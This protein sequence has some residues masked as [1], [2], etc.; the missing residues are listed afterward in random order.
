M[1][2]PGNMPRK[3]FVT[4]CSGPGARRT[5]SCNTHPRMNQCIE[6]L[7]QQNYSPSANGIHTCA[8]SAAARSPITRSKLFKKAKDNGKQLHRPFLRIRDRKIPALKAYAMR[9]DS[10]CS[11][12]CRKVLR[13]T[14]RTSNL[15][16]KIKTCWLWTKDTPLD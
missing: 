8:P 2:T 1:H 9:A 7:L 14:A 11:T 13:I 16:F 5:Y 10:V 3:Y 12:E 15:S 4:L 6:R